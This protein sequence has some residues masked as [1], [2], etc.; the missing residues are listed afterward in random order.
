M[1]H[2]AAG[3]DRET[4]TKK[5]CI[6]PHNPSRSLSIHFRVFRKKKTMVLLREKTT[7]GLANMYLICAARRLSKD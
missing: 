7:T 4:H 6:I 5:M 1:D 2:A 3:V